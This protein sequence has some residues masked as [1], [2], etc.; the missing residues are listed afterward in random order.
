MRLKPGAKF[1]L[2]LVIVVLVV[3][4]VYRLGWL[5]PLLGVVAPDR[6]AGGEVTQDMFPAGAQGDVNAPADQQ[7]DQ[8]PPV[9][10]GAARVAVAG[11]R[12]P[13]CRG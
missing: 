6:K 9:K 11:A 12:R 5:D 4:G 8:T 3:A 1:F 2:F 13:V 10:G 7:P